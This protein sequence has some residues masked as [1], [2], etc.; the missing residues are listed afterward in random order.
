MISFVLSRRCCN[1]GQVRVCSCNIVESAVKHHNRILWHFYFLF[2]LSLYFK[3]C[4]KDFKFCINSMS[5][6]IW[7]V[8]SRSLPVHFSQNLPKNFVQVNSILLFM[9]ILQHALKISSFIQISQIYIYICIYLVINRL[10][11]HFRQNLSSI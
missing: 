6:N 11:V 8:F 9:S 7:F 10:P 4:L 5:I 3:A 1:E 2:Y